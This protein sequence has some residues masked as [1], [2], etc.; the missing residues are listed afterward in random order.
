MEH[1]VDTPSSWELEVISDRPRTSA[2]TKGPS[3]LEVNFQNGYPIFKFLPSS[4]TLSPFS[5]GVKPRVVLLATLC[6]ASS[7]AA[8]ASFLA[9][10][11][12]FNLFSA[13]GTFILSN[14]KGISLDS[15]P[16]MRLNGEVLVVE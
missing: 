15:Y 4:Q 1:G 14:A 11:R 13:V 9:S 5:K 10:L 8:D 6:L 7:C 16:I 3:L 2:I 12:V